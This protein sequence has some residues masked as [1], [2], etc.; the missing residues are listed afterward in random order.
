LTRTLDLPD[1]GMC[2]HEIPGRRDVYLP[3]ARAGEANVEGL[4]LLD[5]LC[6]LAHC[7]S[8]VAGSGIEF[9]DRGVRALRGVP[10]EWRLFRVTSA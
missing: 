2:L 10:G 4:E 3:I 5:R 9:E 7:E 8:L 1:T 6:R